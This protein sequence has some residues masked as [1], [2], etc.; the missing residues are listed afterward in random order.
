MEPRSSP[1]GR[2]EIVEE[3]EMPASAVEDRVYVAVGAECK[4]GKAA[5]IWTIQNFGRPIVITHVHRPAKMIPLL[6]GKFPVSQ[7]QDQQVRAFRQS[8]REKM[9]K[10]MDDYMSMCSQQKVRADKLVI[11]MDDVAKGIVELIAQYGITS[12]VM[13]AAADKHYSK[14]MKAPRSRTATTVKQLADPSCRI[15]FVCKGNLIC[16]RETSLSLGLS[17]SPS[18]T[19]S[20]MSSSFSMSSQSEQLRSRSST[21]GKMTTFRNMQNLFWRRSSSETSSLQGSKTMSVLPHTS[22]SVKTSTPLSRLSLEESIVDE[23]WDELPKR[24]NLPISYPL[25]E[26]EEMLSNSDFHSLT[27]EE[28]SDTSSAILNAVNEPD[29]ELNFSSSRYEMEGIG[30]DDELYEKLQ[31][32]LT[33]A[34]SLRREA[35][36]ES[37]RRQKA[38]KDAFEAIRRANLSESLFSKE[39]KL[40]KEI[41]EALGREKL[42]VEILKNQQYELANELQRSMK[43]KLELESHIADS[44]NCIKG[45][46]EKVSAAYSQ[47]SSLQE[48]HNLLQKERDEAVQKIEVLRQKKEEKPSKSYHAILSEFS[49]SEVEQAT[50]CF[51]H[52]LKIGEGGYGTVYK[53]F[54][55]TTTVAIKMLNSDSMQGRSE[56][57][58]EVNFLSQ[59]RHPNLV[60]LIGSCKEASALIY[61]Y[62]PNGSLEDRLQCK[63]NTPPLSWQARTRIAAEICSALIFL[64]SSKPQP[65]IHGG[66]KPENILLDANLV[67]KLSDFGL[68]RFLL[69]SEGTTLYGQTHPK[70]TFAYMD[71]QCLATGDLTPQSDVY[72]L[73]II[74]LRLLTGKPALGI[75]KEVQEAMVKRKLGGIIDPTAGDWPLVKANQ[76]AQLGLRCCD[77][78][79]RNRPDLAGEV[80]SVVS[81]MMKSA[82]FSASQISFSSIIEDTSRIPNNFICPIFQEVMRDPHIAA[83]GFSYEAEAIRG[84]FDGGHNTSPMTNLKLPHTELIPN[85]VLRSA[86]QEWLQHQLKK[87]F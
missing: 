66:L 52:S 10:N 5:L 26:N 27:R 50:C 9:N 82:S 34:A 21:E 12:L 13:G 72:S 74:I 53:G 1:S 51:T 8:E 54:L 31:D 25:S 46:E 30:A 73:G 79:R 67:S 32:T 3:L 36:K 48:K 87:R 64:H 85:R 45:L 6:G 70:G 77:I 22:S 15:W 58:Q 69:Q 55:R 37:L 83:D 16:T 23:P 18:G 61:E 49:F 24:S 43:E 42:E 28:E 59:V 20:S 47:L 29:E 56:F 35:Y 62:L 75:I 86:I 2:Q 78:N 17:S 33:E 80:W 19:P 60:T 81:P 40:R 41:E 14:R 57:D 68:S 39:V 71:P 4:D 63:D 44:E 11:E 76:L 38:E 7:L 84:W 65:V